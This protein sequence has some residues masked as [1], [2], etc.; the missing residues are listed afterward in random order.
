MDKNSLFLNQIFFSKLKLAIQ[1][2]TE[3]SEP[4][5]LGKNWD[6]KRELFV[7]FFFKIFRTIR[8]VKHWSKHLIFQFNL[9][10]ISKNA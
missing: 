6:Q 9:P 5:V 2:L 7:L 10:F 8:I 3:E 4:V 1:T